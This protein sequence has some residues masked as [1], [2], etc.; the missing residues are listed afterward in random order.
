MSILATLAPPVRNSYGWVRWARP[1]PDGIYDTAGT[2]EIASALS[3]VWFASQSDGIPLG[4][5]GGWTVEVIGD[6]TNDWNDVS[7]HVRYEGTLV[8]FVIMDG[9]GG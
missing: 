6:T 8:G 1:T 5:V 7:L 9:I 2:A 3:V 4:L